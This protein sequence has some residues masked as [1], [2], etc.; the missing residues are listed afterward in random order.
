MQSCSRCGRVTCA[1]AGA[2]P[3][4]TLTALVGSDLKVQAWAPAPARD[5]F[6]GGFRPP[7]GRS[8]DLDRV[9]ALP[10]RKPPVPGTEE[11]RTLVE[12]M[13]PR[14][15]RENVRCECASMG[16]DCI[17]TLLDVQAWTLFEIA[18]VGGVIG[19]ISVGNG[20]T[21][22]DLLAAF[23]MPHCQ[24]A[25]LLCP[26]GLV[27]QLVRDFKRY[28]QHFWMP[29]IVCHGTMDF[30]T[31]PGHPLVRPGAPT[32]NV[33][34]YSQLSNE[35]KTVW[36][37]TTRPD[38]MFADEVH[39]LSDPTSARTIRVMRFFA[40][41][42]S[43]RFAGWTG[44]LSGDSIGEYAHL[45]ALALRYGS[46][47]PTDPDTVREW[48]TAIDAG[49]TADAGELMKLCAPGE[50]VRS[51]FRRRVHDTTGFVHTQAA[52]VAAK[53][54]ITK[55]E[56]KPPKV[57]SDLLAHIRKSG[58]RP[59]HIADGGSD[60]DG[61]W[62]ND[63]LQLKRC[64]REVAC[65]FFYRWDFPNHEPEE[66]IKL[67]LKT[68]AAFAKEVRELIKKREPYLDS[69]KLCQRAAARFYGDA[70]LVD[71]DEYGE[72]STEI[73]DHRA[74]LPRW[75]SEWWIRWRD[76]RDKVKPKTVAVRID[77][78]LVQDAA[79]WARERTGII[80]YDKREFGYWLAEVSG[81]PLYEGGA[82]GGG[83]LYPKGHRLEGHIRETG[84]RSI[85]LSIKAHGTGRDGLQRIFSK[86]LIA[87]PQA[88]ATGSEQLLGR[89][90]RIGQTVD[91]EMDYY[92]HT[93]EFRAFMKKALDRAAYVTGTLG[94]SQKLSDGIDD[95]FVSL[96]E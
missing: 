17:T 21:L 37:E 18:T 41:C 10:R 84:D 93:K 27:S 56:L 7:V 96:E 11:A 15:A 9:L 42:S 45:T 67:W 63:P 16:Y 46:P 40:N 70:Q 12:I 87:Q 68:R 33:L 44:S 64:L 86:G 35:E 82:N 66:L 50:S 30:A 57:V 29:H 88:S 89:L 59:D 83:L 39:C 80:W 90:H 55:R 58:I 32:L 22:I 61:E 71:I 26:S 13:T 23:A 25:V 48:G 94:A 47:L 28:G 34:P 60:T 2:A 14:F 91:V 1:C 85:I 19:S 53:L 92:A 36:L 51:G 78:F 72:R 54:T 49:G 79:K 62:L 31:E 74:G 8:P 76:I 43:T 6:G 52:P 5:F 20:K 75:E 69:P 73:V 81:L 24:R 95:D 65:G 38:S 4:P 77:D 3:P